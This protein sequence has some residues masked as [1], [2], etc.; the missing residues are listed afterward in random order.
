MLGAQR[1]LLQMWKL[2]PRELAARPPE[3]S[4][5]GLC[6]VGILWQLLPQKLLTPHLS[7]LVRFGLDQTDDPKLLR[8]HSMFSYFNELLLLRLLLAGWKV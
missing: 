3:R 1:F 2:G 7:L 8:M 6:A 4:R 5:L